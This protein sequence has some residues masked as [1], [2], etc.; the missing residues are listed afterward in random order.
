M[1][2]GSSGLSYKATAGKGKT[3]TKTNDMTEP[4]WK[5]HN[6]VTHGRLS[7][8]DKNKLPI[9]AFAFPES[10]KEPMT[11]VTHVRD[12]M[13]R[14]NQVEGATVAEKDLAFRNIQKAAKHF[15]V[16]MKETDWHQFGSR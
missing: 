13:A 11:D 7:T 3:T 5:P 4:T 8:A 2:L 10:R 14:F 16:H 6:L 12:A 1:L 9:S 15:D